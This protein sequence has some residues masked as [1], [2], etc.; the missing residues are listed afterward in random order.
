MVVLNRVLSDSSDDEGNEDHDG[1]EDPKSSELGIQTILDDFKT[2]VLS[3]QD[4]R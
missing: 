4:E 3:S 2:A 1:N